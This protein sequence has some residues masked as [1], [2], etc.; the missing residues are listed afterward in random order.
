MSEQNEIVQ[1]HVAAMMAE[2]DE[3]NVPSDLIGRALLNE[4]L[5]IYRRSRGNDDISSELH[6]VAD[7]L[8]PDT[9]FTFMRP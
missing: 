7:N 3:K 8:D 5:D 1:R 2:A 4:V 6:F 9:D